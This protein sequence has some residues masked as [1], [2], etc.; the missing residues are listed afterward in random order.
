MVAASFRAAARSLIYCAVLIPTAVAALAVVVAGR[1][2]VAVRWW[3]GLRVR[4]L[5]RTPAPDGRAGTGGPGAVGLHAVASLLLGAA[6]LVPLGLQLVFVFRSVLYGFVDH[7]PYDTSWG[8]PSRAGAWIAHFLIGLPISAVGLA[9]LV[10]IA[11]LHQRLTG[12]LDGQ[13]RPRW[14]LPV[15]VVVGGL[16]AGFVVAWSRQI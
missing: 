5:G 8:G 14:L 15:T 9:A 4:L 16:A 2:R 13:P 11:A 1:P 12:A 6:A 3:R 10:G 7:G